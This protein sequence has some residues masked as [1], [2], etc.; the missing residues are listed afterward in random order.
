[1]DITIRQEQTEDYGAVHKTVEL[2]F[3]DVEESDHSEPFLVD[4]L[5]QTDAFVPELSLVAE[6]DGKII[7]H[8]LLTKVE[9][10]SENNSVTSLGLA[11]VSVLPKYQ[12]QGVGSALIREA[13]NVPPNWDMV[14]L[15]CWDI[16]TTIQNSVINKP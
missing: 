14:R 16:R 11:P 1:M 15:S 12:K 3:K 2:A 9:I 5:R 8:I 13:Q 10:V 7:G 6:T 4:K